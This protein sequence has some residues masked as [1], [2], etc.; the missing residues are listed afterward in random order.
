MKAEFSKQNYFDM[1]HVQQVLATIL[2]EWIMVY[3]S[4]PSI[5]RENL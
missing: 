5:E 4:A 2:H 3:T 1:N